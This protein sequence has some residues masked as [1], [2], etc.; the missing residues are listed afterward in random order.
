MP[1]RLARSLLPGSLLV[2]LLLVYVGPF[3]RFVFFSL[4]PCRRFNE[5]TLSICTAEIEEEEELELSV[6][7]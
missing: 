7:R 1:E 6:A 3:S 4:F 5:V 2:S